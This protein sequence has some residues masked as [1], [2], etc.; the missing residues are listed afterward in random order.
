MNS[1]FCPRSNATVRLENPHL[2]PSGFP[3]INRT[4]LLWFINLRKRC[5]NSSGVS[6]FS[7]STNCESGAWAGDRLVLDWGVNKE[8]GFACFARDLVSA[9]ASAPDI[10][11]RRVCP[12]RSFLSAPLH[13]KRPL[14]SNWHEVL[15]IAEQLRLRKI[16]R[17][18]LVRPHQPMKVHSKGRSGEKN[19]GL[20]I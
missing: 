5:S 10:R 9:A 15:W 12:C 14:K 8:E 2:G 20:R 13:R 16:L 17:C 4:T 6:P 3:F 11:S 18:L 19:R 7:S 1:T